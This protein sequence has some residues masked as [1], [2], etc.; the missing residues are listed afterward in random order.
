MPQKKR[1]IEL[2]APQ[3]FTTPPGMPERQPQ[4]H[5]TTQAY[6]DLVHSTGSYAAPILGQAGAW[7]GTPFGTPGRMTGAAI[8]AMLGDMYRQSGDD[9]PMNWETVAREGTGYALS[10]GVVPGLKYIKNT[11]LGGKLGK[12][13]ANAYEDWQ[14]GRAART[15]AETGRRMTDEE[16]INEAVRRTT[17]GRRAAQNAVESEIPPSSP[18]PSSPGP[19]SP[20]PGAG[21][22]RPGGPKTGPLESEV[23]GAASTPGSP[24]DYSTPPYGGELGPVEGGGDLAT[25]PKQPGFSKKETYFRRNRPGT[26]P[27]LNQPQVIHGGAAPGSVVEPSGIGTGN[28]QSAGSLTRSA[29]V[30]QG[31]SSPF[32]ETP[33][34]EAPGGEV[35]PFSSRFGSGY[36]VPP[37]SPPPN[38]PNGRVWPLGGLPNYGRDLFS[39]KRL[40]EMYPGAAVRAIIGPFESRFRDDA[41]N[42]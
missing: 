31:H 3:I 13:A 9:D 37:G 6:R 5:K 7:L 1:T 11:K 2:E 21:P 27:E 33:R 34:L 18:R 29:E 14:A 26:S 12:F 32:R 25:R 19:S 23:T 8:G 24:P 30:P 36:Q 15:A 16:L 38:P 42:R 20:K 4:E 39:G 35:S 40:R 10:E 41:A 28:S 17:A 22:A